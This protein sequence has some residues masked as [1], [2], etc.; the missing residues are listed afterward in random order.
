LSFTYK[1]LAKLIMRTSPDRNF[2]FI[3]GHKNVITREENIESFG[4]MMR[5]L[6]K[7]HEERLAL[8]KETDGSDEITREKLR[9]EI[10][11][12]ILAGLTRFSKHPR[13][14]L[15]DL[16]DALKES[17]HSREDMRHITAFAQAVS[18]V[19]IS[20]NLV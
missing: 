8:A 9:V 3:E 20:L 10:K 11:M 16:K 14:D 18:E 2:K 1:V 6:D 5:L 17:A 7:G 15:D 4:K 19:L 13:V 12:G